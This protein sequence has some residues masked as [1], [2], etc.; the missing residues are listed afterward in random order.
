MSRAPKDPELVKALNAD[1]DAHVERMLMI[2]G[3]MSVIL[4]AELSMVLAERIKNTD[5]IE[6]FV[7][8]LAAIGLSM[9]LRIE[10]ARLRAKVEAERRPK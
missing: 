8:E 3:E 7:G 1:M 5:S 2:F 9:V 6:V 10:D 4:R